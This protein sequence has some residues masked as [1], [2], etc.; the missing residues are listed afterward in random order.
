MMTDGT[1]GAP[2]AF[3]D[4]LPFGEEIQAGIGGRSALYDLADPKQKFTGKE[5]DAETGNDWFLKR[6]F[7]SPMGRFTSPDPMGITKQKLRDPQQWNMYA[8]SRNNPLRFMDPTGMYVTSCKE[9]DVSKCDQNTQDFEAARQRNLKS[10]DKDV[11]ASA[12]AYG[13]YGQTGVT[14]TFRSQDKGGGVVTFDRDASGKATGTLTV[15]I[16]PE[17][18]REASK[19]ALGQAATDAEVAHEGTHV[20]DDLKLINSGFQP[21]YDITH[22]ETERHAYSTENRVIE[23]EVNRSNPDWQSNKAIDNFLKANP[24]L[25]PNPDAPILDPAA[26]P[27]GN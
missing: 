3:H 18:L 14:V 17:N 15:N 2:V 9:K 19:G 13:G 8:Y 6:Y 10:S 21:K 5:R 7:G 24:T 23:T 4:Y 1:T 26:I 11:R 20:K 22:R 25:Y 12:K 16:T 27:A